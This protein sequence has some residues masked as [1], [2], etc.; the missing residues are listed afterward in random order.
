[1]G[2]DTLII[3]G[4]AGLFVSAVTMFFVAPESRDRERPAPRSLP[5]RTDI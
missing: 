2:L 4:V 1:M 5:N 3:V